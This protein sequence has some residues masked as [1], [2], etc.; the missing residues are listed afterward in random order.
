MS[1][2]TGRIHSI[3]SLGTVD[4]PGVRFVA[5]L[6]G[7]PLCCGCCHNPDTWD[8]CG[9]SESTPTQLVQKALRYKEYFG[10]EGGITLSGGEPLLQ[11]EFAC[12]VF[13]LCRK[14]GLHTCLD[15]SGCLLNDTVKALL[16][17]TDR[18]LLDIK[19]TDDALYRSHVGCSLQK[20]LEFLAYL[21]QQNIPTT[22]RQ[23]IIPTLNDTERNVT[24]LKRIAAQHPCVDKIELLPFRK[25]CQ[26]KYDE[27]GIPFAFE[28]LPEPTA[29]QMTTLNQLLNQ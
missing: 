28:H 6:Q 26:V 29:Q 2:L 15:T 1:D 14:E 13:A 20:P 5:F 12:E 23:V 10:S 4:G 8:V 25:I 11:A 9:G 19:Y 3:Q 7:C 18:V 24:E 17:E 16:A 21:Q 22:L 27:I